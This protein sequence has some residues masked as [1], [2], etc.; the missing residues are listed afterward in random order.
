[1][2]LSAGL[3]SASP[4]GAFDFFDVARQAKQLAGEKYKAPTSQLPKE[5]RELK[6]G[7]YQQIQAKRD[8]Y[9]WADSRSPFQIAFHHQGMA[10]DLPVKVNEI[11]AEGVRE[12]KYDP[13]DFDFGPRQPDPKLLRDLG[14]AGFRILYPLND[15]AKRDDELAS[16]LGASYFRMV[17]KGQVYGISARGLA[18]D[19]AVPSGEEFPRFR[20]FWIARPANSDK[21]VVVYALLDSP[22]ATGAYRFTIHPGEDTTVEVRS[23][24]YLRAPVA[25]L[26]IA[27]MTSMYLYGAAQPSGTLNFRPELHDSD[28]L[29]FHSGNGEWLWRPLNNPRRLANSSFAVENPRGFGLQQRARDFRQYEDLD[30]RYDLRPTLWVEPS[31]NW[32]KGRIELVEI[33]TADETNDNIV[34]FWVP[35]QQ[36]KPGTALDLNY[37]L[38]WTR[39]EAALQDPTLARVL[40]TRRSTGETKG[41]DLIRRPDGSTAFVID[42]SEPAP[43]KPKDPPLPVSLNF[44][45]GGNADVIENSLRRNPVTG[46]WRVTLRIKVK[47]TTKPVEMRANLVNGQTPVSE[48]WSYQLPGY[49]TGE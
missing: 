6:Y 36:P 23:R 41:A 38:R 35:E 17:G 44:S 33:P 5:L 3:L 9:L 43:A 29:A 11:D 2:A 47:D 18:I 39:N 12:I 49:E 8:K 24:V 10:F 21:H 31:G 45:T 22:R 27:A 40:Q 26:G 16:F 19:T 30:D 1:M 14:F 37:T 7:D 20:E 46:G 42:F 15:P 13:A 48:T 32:G 25:K 28:G 4:A 34:A